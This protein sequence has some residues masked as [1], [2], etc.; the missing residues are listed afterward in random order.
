L[1]KQQE[2]KVAIT[3]HGPGFHH[4]A[5]RAYDFDKTLAFYEEGLGFER[6]YGWGEPGS[7]AAMLGLGDG[8]YLEVFEGGEQLKEVPDGVLM[9]YAVRVADAEAAYARALSAGAGSQTPP[10][11]VDIAGD[12]TVQV[13]IA[14]VRGLDGEVIEFFQNEE[15]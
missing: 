4:L 3:K 10:M 5:F 15:L 11:T 8:N 12:R 7:R 9:H 1:Q 6:A 2:N 13:R 14:F